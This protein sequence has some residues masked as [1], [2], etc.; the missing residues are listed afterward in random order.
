MPGMCSHFFISVA[1]SW[2]SSERCTVWGSMN[3]FLCVLNLRKTEIA[4]DCAW[5]FYLRYSLTRRIGFETAPRG[6]LYRRR[7]KIGKM[8]CCLLSGPCKTIQLDELVRQNAQTQD[9]FR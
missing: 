4:P 9:C 1:L 8:S 7:F 6:Y 3:L 2:K 5:R